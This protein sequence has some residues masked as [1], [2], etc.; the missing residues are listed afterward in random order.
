VTVTPEGIT[1]YPPTREGNPWRAVWYD[2]DGKRRHCQAQSEAKMVVKLEPVKARLK[3]D[4]DRAQCPVA[5]LIACY[6]DPSRKA[7]DKQWSFSYRLVQEKR[8]ARILAAIGHLTCEEIRLIHVQQIVNAAPTA[9]SGAK[10]RSMVRAV[11][12]LGIDEGFLTN[13]RLGAV[14]WE[15]AGR[16]MRKGKVRLA[17]ESKH[18]VDPRTLPGHRDVA[19]LAG[20][21]CCPTLKMRMSASS[22][23]RLGG[24]GNALS[25]V[26]R[27]G[28][29]SSP[30]RRDRR[31]VAGCQSLATSV[32][33]ARAED[34]STMA[35]PAANAAIS[36]ATPRL[37][38]ARGRPRAF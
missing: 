3:A 14:R 12:K 30:C 20:A 21:T 10:M 26:S 13:P 36:A 5:D 34:S 25:G 32:T 17:G 27:T 9:D 11:V 8:C 23:S 18:F 1:V 31:R 35:F 15:A 6:L 28:R 19:I 33:A 37:F 38:T 29:L 24:D 16:P 22:V 7:E 2:P 4:A